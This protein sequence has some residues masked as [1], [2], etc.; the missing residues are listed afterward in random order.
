M[1]L[2]VRHTL[3]L[4]AL[5]MLV[6]CGEH[7]DII[8]RDVMTNIYADMLFADQWIEDHVAEHTKAD[9]TLFYDPIFKR[10][11]YTFEEYDKSVQ[12]Y[13]QDPERFSK[14]FRDAAVILRDKSKKYGA[15]AEKA[16]AARDFN[17]LIKG[18]EPRDFDSDTILWKAPIT[19]SLILDS[20]RRDSLLRDSLLMEQLRLDSLIRDSLRLDSLKVLAARHDSIMRRIKVKDRPMTITNL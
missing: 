13:M 19:D 6:A 9:T 15:L 18:Y 4:L 2:N 16:A 12:Y 14:L 20:L 17:A 5:L 1:K 8:P 3:P 10:Y 11:G 7:R